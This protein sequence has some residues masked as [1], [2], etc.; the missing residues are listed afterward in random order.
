MDQLEEAIQCVRGL[1]RDEV[2]DFEGTV[3]PAPRRPLR[4]EAGAGRAA[5]LG[6]RPGREAHA[7]HRG[8]VGRRLERPVRRRPRPSP[9]S[10]TCCT[11]TATSVG[12]DPAEIRTAVNVGLAWTEESL[13]Q[14]FGGLADFV[15]PGVLTGSDDEVVDRIGQYVDAGADQVNLAL[16]A[17]FDEEALDRFAGGARARARD[18]RR[19]GRPGRVNLIG[20][21]TDY[22]G[23]FVLPMAIDRW[24]T[25]RG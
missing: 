18:G 3:L 13:R 20:D 1:L 22:T 21:H 19:R 11:S 5:D 25:V 9:T 7:A 23:G 24:T 6:R 10:A 2:D 12:R 4:A 17:P 16:R 8:P 15:R 14:Q